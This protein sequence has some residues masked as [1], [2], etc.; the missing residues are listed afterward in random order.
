M[1]P[2]ER[3]RSATESL[4]A[5]DNASNQHLQTSVNAAGEII[6]CCVYPA[7]AADAGIIDSSDCI[8]GMLIDISPRYLFCVYL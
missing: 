4:I 2:F 6:Y 1:E 8:T 3:S 5:A 7:T